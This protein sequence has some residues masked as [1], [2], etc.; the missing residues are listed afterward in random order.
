MLIPS[1]EA[2]ILYNSV[3]RKLLLY[4]FVCATFLVRESRK[5]CRPRDNTAPTERKIDFFVIIK[6]FY[7]FRYSTSPYFEILQRIPFLLFNLIIISYNS[8]IIFGEIRIKYFV[9][10]LQKI[11][12]KGFPFKSKL[13]YNK[14]IQQ[15]FSFLAL[16]IDLIKSIH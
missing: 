10:Y 1:I 7:P 9:I 2:L 11:D 16:M 8:F 3:H 13:P 4:D 14:N 5:L 12:K 6:C 15:I